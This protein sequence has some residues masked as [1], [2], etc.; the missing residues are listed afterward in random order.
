MRVKKIY[1]LVFVLLAIFLV[2][3]GNQN[4]EMAVAKNIDKNA[5]RLDSIIQKL[6]NMNYDD[7]IIQD[8]N[9]L[10]DNTLN[11]TNNV[12]TS[13][14]YD[15]VN[16][17]IINVDKIQKTNSYRTKSL[18]NNTSNLFSNQ[19]EEKY[20]NN[21]I[22]P[23]Y[24]TPKYI[25]QTSSTFTDQNLTNYINK[26]ENLYK[27]CAD[28][29]SCNT[30]CRNETS[31]LK[32]NISDCKVLSKKLKDGTIKLSN[33]EITECNN[34]L[35]NLFNLSNRLASTKDNLMLKEKDILDLKD[36]FSKNID[37]LQVAYEKL[38]TALE[39]RLEYLQTCNKDLCVV[40]DIINKTN[41]DFDVVEKNRSNEKNIVYDSNTNSEDRNSVNENQN[42]FDNQSINSSNPANNQKYDVNNLK[43]N[44]TNQ[45]SHIFNNQNP[46]LPINQNMNNANNQNMNNPT[47]QNYVNGYPNN[48]YGYGYNY[49][50]PYRNIDT[51][52]TI[53]RN[54]DTYAPNY[55]PNIGQNYNNQYFQNT[56]LTAANAENDDIKTEHVEE[57]NELD[58]IY[59]DTGK[60]IRS[61]DEKI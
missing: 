45:N 32:Q 7:I 34:C 35:D 39:S 11:T 38:L 55:N 14:M 59:G 3:C 41:V 47:N 24:Y 15:V 52:R 29:I 37:N 17:R 36:N 42:V 60:P 19:K 26:I 10:K 51:Y 50:Y 57:K 6:D 30:E 13:K 53:T 23:G 2:G 33:E 56:M 49:G 8:I 27:T 5:N 1:M 16:N 40:C 31:N 22:K 18:S 28:C 4:T 43:N 21:T 9:P 61:I 25:N 48:Q 46:N 20:I 58:K 54:T 44:Q 12:E